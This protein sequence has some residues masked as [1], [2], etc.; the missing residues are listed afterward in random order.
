[1]NGQQEPAQPDDALVIET[2]H[3][4]PVTTPAERAPGTKQSSLR[5]VELIGVFLLIVLCDVTIYHGQGFAGY[6]ALFLIAPVLLWVSS[7]RRSGGP[8][9]WIVSFMMLALAAKMLWC[10]SNALVAVGFALI[11]AF[12][13][14][15]VGLCP[16]VLEMLFFAL[17]TAQA[18]FYGIVRFGRQ[19]NRLG[20]IIPRAGWV[21]IVL[22]LLA[23]LVFSWIFVL[24]NPDLN[25]W[26]GQGMTQL[27]KSVQVWVEQYSPD[28]LQIGFWAAVLWI[29][30]GLLR[31]VI[32]DSQVFS[33]TGETPTDEPPEAI[34]ADLYPALRNTLV[35]VVVLFGVYLVF[36]FQSMWFHEFPPGFHYSGYAHEG[37]AWLTAALALATIMLSLV[38]RGDILRERRVG[39]LRRLAW[40]WSIE[41][42]L[43]AASV[44]NR[45]F[46]YIG[47]NG[48]SRMRIVGLFG[49]TA[50]VVGFLL[51]IWKIARNRN[52]FWLARRH[53]WTLAIA[54]Y[55][56]ALTPLDTLV[57]GYNVRRI[58]DG[59]PAP[60][61][62][63]SVHP[64]NSEGILQLQ[65]LLNSDNE[66]I[67]E[68]V[69]ALLALHQSE[70]ESTATRR[71]ALGW[72]TYQ[73]ADEIA[74]EEFRRNQE[75]W[76]QYT[77]PQVR[78]AALDRF[79]KYA[80]QW[81]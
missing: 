56:L 7:N 35:T 25:V 31:P 42:M 16:Y 10:G 55:L 72:T 64:I 45:L 19:L 67:R 49:M 43:L 62:Q 57:V 53:L 61:V 69:R 46:I 4:D 34:D 66:I 27:F 50:V 23:F 24:A 13:M 2:F 21:S 5:W 22:P 52:L 79:H 32:V 17:Q 71:S 40:L 47:F 6:A 70:A 77:D 26:F 36:E 73:I 78:Q 38:F 12:A 29:A 48:M 63:I 28:P 74:L 15:L 80:Y 65:P 81:F 3:D 51:V 14:T 59:D 76:Q 18:G 1:M 44:Y 11:V 60:S 20:P 39:S 37:A 54:L 8:A 68:G 41:N 9:F 30:L 58:L 33:S 75:A